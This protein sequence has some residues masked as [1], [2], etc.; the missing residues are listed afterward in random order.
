M[1]MNPTTAL[2][3][4]QHSHH[5]AH[6]AHGV[7]PL[8]HTPH[9]PIH[10]DFEEFSNSMS[11]FLDYSTSLHLTAANPYAAAAA[12]AVASGNLTFI[13]LLISI[14]S[15]GGTRITGMFGI[16]SSSGTFFGNR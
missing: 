2:P 11:P 10:S 14:Q 16:T 7:G 3:A 8:H 12:A 13:K 15:T 5:H 9:H 1:A 4:H 6:E